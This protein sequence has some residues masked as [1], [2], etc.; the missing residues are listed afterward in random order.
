MSRLSV[1]L[2][3]MSTTAVDHPWDR[4]PILTI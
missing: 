4:L 1:Q 2:T 3:W